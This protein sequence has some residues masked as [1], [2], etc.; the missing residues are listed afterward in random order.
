MYA[1]LNGEVKPVTRIKP[2]GPRRAGMLWCP[3]CG[4]SHQLPAA[5][6]RG[7]CGAVFAE[8]TSVPGAAPPFVKD[9]ILVEL[10]ENAPGSTPFLPNERAA[11]ELTE[12]LRGQIPDELRGP[13]QGKN[14][15]DAPASILKPT[16][17]EIFLPDVRVEDEFARQVMRDNLPPTPP[18]HAEPAAPPAARPVKAVAK[19]TPRA[20]KRRR[21]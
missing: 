17:T 14:V 6:C 13:E 10:G 1:V 18:E 9:I 19:K 11:G 16:S 21:P 12:P 20:A 7:G 5:E 2:Q 3:F 4:R 8:M 15:S